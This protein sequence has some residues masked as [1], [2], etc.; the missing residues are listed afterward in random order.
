MSLTQGRMRDRVTMWIIAD[1]PDAVGPAQLTYRLA[2]D[3]QLGGLQ[4][5]IERENRP[6]ARNELIGCNRAGNSD[7]KLIEENECIGR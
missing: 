4:K 5:D 7:L 1:D 6:F 2:T 3:A